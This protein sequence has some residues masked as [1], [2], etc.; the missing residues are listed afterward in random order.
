[1]GIIIPFCGLSGAGKTT[2]AV[3]IASKMI[4]EGLKVLVMDGDHY[5]QSLCK[6][7]GFSKADRLENVRRIKEEA[8]NLH[9]GYDLI[10]MALINPFEEGRAATGNA[11][12]LVWIKCSLET[13]RERDTK[14]LYFKA[15]L[16]D[17]H[18]DKIYNLTGV[19][20]TFEIP[21]QAGLV[22]ET[23]VM[24]LEES[25]DS[26]YSFLMV[27]VGKGQEVIGG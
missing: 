10:I 6:D 5:R 24:S 1:M 25:L 27:K 15:Y 3:A 12:E 14:G 19:N 16:P 26:L 4:A 2:L 13:L 8:V 20:D 22:I 17:G 11:E 23:D 21:E 18:P 7:L 9:A